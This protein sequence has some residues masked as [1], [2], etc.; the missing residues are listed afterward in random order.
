MRRWHRLVFVAALAVAIAACSSSEPRVQGSTTTLAVSS[1]EM[2]TAKALRNPS[3]AG[4]QE[5][6]RMWAY[7]YLRAS[8]AMLLAVRDPDPDRACAQD[9][10]PSG[11][12]AIREAR[13][14][15]RTFQQYV[16]KQ[17]GV[18]AANVIVR[19]VKVRNFAGTTGDAEAT[20]GY[21]ESIEGNAN[22][23]AYRYSH[24]YW[25]LAGCETYAPFGGRESSSSA[26]VGNASN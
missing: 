2:P 17:V 11:P 16:Q 15:L 7:G 4:L 5:A 6:A 25:H 19:S 23:N 10:K 18:A 12:A 1:S 21:P 24:G 22:W 20:Y 8:T 3:R 13:T 9:R 26:A 14:Y